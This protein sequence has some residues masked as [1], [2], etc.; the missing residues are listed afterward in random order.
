M[1]IPMGNA[2]MDMCAKFLEVHFLSGGTKQGLEHCFL[3][4]KLACQLPNCGW[5]IH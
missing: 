3:R 2:F 1:G 4:A 5:M